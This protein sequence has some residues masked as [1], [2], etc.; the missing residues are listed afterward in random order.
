[1]TNACAFL[2]KHQSCL[3]TK[4]NVFLWN[5]LKCKSEVSDDNFVHLVAVKGTA[6]ADKHCVFSSNTSN[7]AAV[8][9]LFA[10]NER[11]GVLNIL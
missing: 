1:M 3:C 8:E 10:T 2:Q 6:V 11:T 9:P 4:R 7:E 5:S